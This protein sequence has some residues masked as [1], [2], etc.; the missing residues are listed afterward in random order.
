MADVCDL[1]DDVIEESLNR[2]IAQIPRYTGISAKECEE[3]G[4]D[5]PELRR[6]AVRGVKLCTECGDRAELKA[7]GVRRG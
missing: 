2:S 4:E 5:I 6:A 7:K 3:C 1:A